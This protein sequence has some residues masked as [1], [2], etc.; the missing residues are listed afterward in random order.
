MVMSIEELVFAGSMPKNCTPPFISVLEP[1]I[2]KAVYCGSPCFTSDFFDKSRIFLEPPVIFL[3]SNQMLLPSP[4]SLSRVGSE[5]ERRASIFALVVSGRADL[6]CP[7]GIIGGSEALIRLMNGLMLSRLSL[8]ICLRADSLRIR[9][10]ASFETYPALR[11][12]S[13]SS[14]HLIS[15]DSPCISV[16]S[17]IYESIWH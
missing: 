7:S 1:S 9:V 6:C 2:E 8:E 15:M 4:L 14:W 17:L 16:I 10:L 5:A 11:S 12:A 13:I 3:V